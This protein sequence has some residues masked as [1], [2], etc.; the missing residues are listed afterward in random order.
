MKRKIISLFLML[1][2]MLSAMATVTYSAETKVQRTVYDYLT[3][4]LDLCPAAAA[5]IMGNIM[6]ECSFNPAAGHYDTNGL[7]SHGLMQ[8]NGPRFEA[9]KSFCAKNGYDYNGVEGQLEWLKYELNNTERGAYKAMKNIPN[10]TE[11]ACRAAVVWADEFERCTKTSYALRIFYAMNTFWPDYAGGSVS[12]T[13]GIYGYYYNVPENIKCGEPLTLYGAIVSYSSEL[14]TIT[15]GV[16]T[17]SGELLT[18]RSL[19]RTG[20]A[21]NIGQIDAFV[22]MNKLERGNYY[23]TI[24]ASNASGEYIVDRR[25][26]TVSDNPT[27]ANLIYESQGGVICD[28]GASCPGLAFSDMPS[29]VSWDHEGIDFVLKEGLFKGNPGGIFAPSETMNR[30]MFVTV[31]ERMYQNYNFEAANGGSETAPDISFIDVPD[32]QYYTDAVKWAASNGIVDG[33]GEGRFAPEESLTRAQL[34]TMMYRFAEKYGISTD[35]AAD[36]SGFADAADVPD[37]AQVEMAWAL[38]AGLVRGNNDFGVLKID[39]NAPATRAQMAA[40]VQRFAA[41]TGVV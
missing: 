5:G 6:I 41:Y 35:G 10:T 4:E 15:A 3:K 33:V 8:W 21:G 36:F 40:I 32:G 20:L 7:W 24:T 34:V 9:L 19:P 18:G 17:E 30:A 1:A 38:E 23:Y 27:K 28:F 13:P 11:G 22:V 14:K 12:N 16:Y 25:S 26:F 29:A 39:P 31:L 37:W 2:V